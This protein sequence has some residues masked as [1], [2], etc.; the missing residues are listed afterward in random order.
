M[1]SS[2][3]SSSSARVGVLARHMALAAAATGVVEDV[4]DIGVAKSAKK[5]PMTTTT[6]TCATAASSG[7]CGSCGEEALNAGRGAKTLT[8]SFTHAAS[9]SSSSSPPAAKTPTITTPAQYVDSLRNRRLRVFY[10]GKLVEEPTEHKAIIPSINAVAETYRLGLAEPDLATAVST[11]SGYR[12]SRFL[13][14][15]A[16]VDDV[17]KQ[18][19]MQR[20]LGQLTGTCFQRC[21]GMD[22]ANALFSVTHDVDA[23]YKTNFHARFVKF[24]TEMQK[25]NYVLGGAMTDGKG[26]RS[27]RPSEQAD[28]DVHLR[29]VER[30]VDGIVVTGVKTH[31]TGCVN[32][33]Y[34][35]VMPGGA[36]AGEKEREFA[37]SF[38]VPVDARGITYVIGRQSCDLRSLEPAEDDVD[39]GNAKFGGQEAVVIFDRVFVPNDMV[40]LDGQTEFCQP[41]VER[42]TAYHRRSYACKAGVG[43]VVI[44]AASAMATYNGI[45]KASHV[46]DKLVEMAF[47]NQTIFGTALAASHLSNKTKAGNF[48]PDVLTANVCKHHVTRLPYELSRLAQDIAGGLVVTLPSSLDF[49]NPETGAALNRFL[50]GASGVSTED[51]RRMLRLIENLT[52]GRNAVGYLT[53]SMHGAGSPQ[54]QRV[55][56]QRLYHFDEC[57]AHAKKLAGVAVVAKGSSSANA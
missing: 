42:F 37:V 46:K 51:R 6:T 7:G 22:A 16:S 49:S 50:Q 26:D 53:E 34:L 28:L 30:R 14:I 41:L 4:E 19:Y 3:S 35:V 24:L 38:A 54:A 52:L 29:V 27:K 8:V 47:L 11:L 17:V 36:L 31:Q 57:V 40:F 43:D 20:K 25:H 23:K 13:H 5:K 2:S 44:G 15:T 12:V 39:L 48:L 1:R 10:L 18:T 56:I 21:V 45:S 33:H 9:S 32:S 55:M